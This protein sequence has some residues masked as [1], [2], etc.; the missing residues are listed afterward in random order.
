MFG[1][2]ILGVILVGWCFYFLLVYK[3]E[4]TQTAAFD[5]LILGTGAGLLIAAVLLVI[6][7]GR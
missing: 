1:I 6:A 2:F 5:D 3:A 7:L 4:G